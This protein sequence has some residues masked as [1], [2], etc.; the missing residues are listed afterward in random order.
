VTPEIPV[1]TPV[2]TDLFIH[3][4]PAGLFTPG[5]VE[6]YD[7]P[8]RFEKIEKTSE[9]TE[10]IFG[11]TDEK[12]E[13]AWLKL[14]SFA[15][16]PFLENLGPRVTVSVA[17]QGQALLRCGLR[18][19][20]F[21][22]AYLAEQR[23]KA[24]TPELFSLSLDLSGYETGRLEIWL[25]PL[26]HKSALFPLG[27]AGRAL[28]AESPP[29]L[30]NFI[31]PKLDLCCETS[32]YYRFQ[33]TAHYSFESESAV[34][35]NKGDGVDLATYFNAFSAGKWR[36]YTNV[37]RLSATFDFSGRALAAIVHLL[38]GCEMV[39]ETFLLA[40]EQ[41]S[42]LTS[43]A[44]KAPEKGLLA[45]R[46]LALE[47]SVLYGGG[48]ATDCPATR[49]V[50]LGIA[51]TTYK[52]EETIK[53]TAARLGAAIRN[54]PRHAVS[55][56][57]VDNGQTL[58]PE[59]VPD[60]LLIPNRNLGGAGGFTRGL[61]HYQ[62]EGRVSHVL[63]MD[64]DAFCET[65]SIFRAL[66]LLE[67]ALK[68]EAAVSGGML[69]ES[70]QYMQWENGAWFKYRCRPL[71]SNLDL[72]KV[73]NLL[74]NDDEDREE[75]E[76]FDI[77]GAWWFFM[78][79]ASL[80]KTYVPPYFVRG[81]D[82][83]FGYSNDFE[84]IRLNGVSCWQEDFKAKESPLVLYL[85]FRSHAMNHLVLAGLPGGARGI[86]GMG[87][88]F[89]N[90]YNSSYFYDSARAIIQAFSDIQEGPEYWLKNLDMSEKRAELK[91]KYTREIFQPAPKQPA[92]IWVDS[93]FATSFLAKAERYL[94]GFGHLIPG[95]IFSKRRWKASIYQV[96]NVNLTYLRPRVQ[97][98][99][100]LSKEIMTLEMNRGRYFGNLFFFLW[101]SLKFFWRF[102][103]LKRTYRK[104]FNNFQ[105]GDFWR[106][107]FANK[108]R[109]R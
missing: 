57:I 96:P 86:V 100:P 50:T 85:D 95:F 93:I 77:Y 45:C 62:D 5:E 12:T 33:G 103:R 11:E 101:T 74:A 15:L 76:G 27:P 83:F 104:F 99:N 7:C 109:E 18:R 29:L 91:A 80:V 10:N 63:F 105:K 55:L 73:K 89:F 88:R 51:V 20:A 6:I 81:D 78:F 68:P 32:L 47:P 53:K 41:R 24:E 72:R 35:P 75:T 14:K 17:F 66:A 21:S 61:I 94:S 8:F 65:E 92:L 28:E 9:R 23:L 13:N 54:H 69:Y 60:A 16:E 31:S 64:D 38:D 2:F 4:S 67:H 26:N 56:A 19:K 70:L 106:A 71:H 79:P 37:D 49:S 39:L 30:Q 84:T 98:E 40:G 102:N 52:R 25:L 1:I 22:Y 82:I 107:A 90:K 3:V 34:L 59:D 43:P 108:E 58:A 48:F 42:R 46:L 87:W 44:F 97:V 36:K